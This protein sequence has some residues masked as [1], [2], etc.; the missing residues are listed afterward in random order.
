M[1]IYFDP[2]PKPNFLYHLVLDLK[3]TNSVF[4]VK[5]HANAYILF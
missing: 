5:I 4:K 2:W 3:H 1:E